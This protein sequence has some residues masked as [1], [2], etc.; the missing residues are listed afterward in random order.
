ML[1]MYVFATALGLASAA[2]V[3]AAAVAPTYPPLAVLK[4]FRLVVQVTERSTSNDFASIHNTYISNIRTGHQG[5]DLLG[6]TE[7]ADKALTFYLNGTTT[8]QEYMRVL[9]ESTTSVSSGI[10][11]DPDE[12]SRTVRTAYLIEGAA[13]VG[14]SLKHPSENYAFLHPETWAACKEKLPLDK[15]REVIVFKQAITTTSHMFGTVDQNIPKG[16]VSVRLLPECA[17]LNDLPK[18]SSYLPEQI[19]PSHQHVLGSHCYKDVKAID[20]SKYGP[21]P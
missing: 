16:C 21:G 6:Q 15:D 10:R 1:N 20:W 17:N 13:D 5:H 8:A 18:F 9:T 12:G 7:N 19:T 11:L 4:A 2:A 14:F 3:A